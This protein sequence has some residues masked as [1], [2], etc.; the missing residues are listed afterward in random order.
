[1]STGTDQDRLL[2]LVD[3]VVNAD[4]DG[5]QFLA[6]VVAAGPAHGG[7]DDVGDTADREP[8]VQQVTQEG[9][10]AAEGTVTDQD[11]AQHELA[12]QGLGDRQIKQDA[13]VRT[14][15]GE[16]LVEGLLG[17]V[18]LLVDELTA[19]VVFLG[20][21]GNGLAAGE[22]VHG[23]P[24]ALRRGQLLGGTGRDRGRGPWA[25]GAAR[26]GVHVCFL[27]RRGLWDN[28]SVGRRQTL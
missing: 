5:G 24:L 10:D 27:L 6:L 25:R 4:A 26:M 8:V 9:D 11:Q 14:A 13:L 23:Q 12:E 17:L 7:P 2:G 21:A 1:M 20:Q 18:G 15:R 19:D 22:G 3:L 28:P 16:G